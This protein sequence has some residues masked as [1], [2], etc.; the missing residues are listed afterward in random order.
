MDFFLEQYLL[1]KI[2]PRGLRVLKQCS[3]LDSNLSTEWSHISEFCTAKWIG[4]LVQ[5]RDRKF[6]TLKEK[7]T[8]LCN[9][10]QD[11]TSHLPLTWLVTL[12][13]NTKKNED[14]FI[15]NKLG[16]F[17]RDLDYYNLDKVFFLEKK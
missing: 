16:K 17:R 15:C 1:H 3:F 12:K 9:D 7:I 11:S 10:I 6:Q 5:Q 4:L 2:T 13:K 14:T 8:E